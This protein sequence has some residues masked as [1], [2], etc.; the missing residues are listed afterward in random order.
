MDEIYK[1]ALDCYDKNHKEGET[2]KI[3]ARITYK[4][5]E[6]DS[7]DKVIDLSFLE[8]KVTSLSSLVFEEK[9]LD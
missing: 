1:L 5:F 4:A 7:F 9:G 8:V 3:E 6:Y 2:F